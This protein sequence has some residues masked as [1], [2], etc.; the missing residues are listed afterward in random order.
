VY[1][2]NLKII[3]DLRKKL[4]VEDITYEEYSKKYSVKISKEI[5]DEFSLRN[6]QYK[7]IEERSNK[8]K[9]KKSNLAFFLALVL[10]NIFQN[11]VWLLLGMEVTWISFL[12]VGFQLMF[13]STGLISFISITLFLVLLPFLL[14]FGFIAILLDKTK[15]FHNLTESENK[16]IAEHDNSIKSALKI[17]LENA[18]KKHIEEKYSEKKSILAEIISKEKENNTLVDN[19]LIDLKK[20]QEKSYTYLISLI[21]TYSQKTI[22]PAIEENFNKFDITYDLTPGKASSSLLD[23]FQKLT[24][25]LT[26]KI[27][28]EEGLT[29]YGLVDITRSTN[30]DLGIG[31][32][33]YSIQKNGDLIL[34]ESPYII[35]YE[36]NNSSHYALFDSTKYKNSKNKKTIIKNN[37]IHDFQLFGSE[38]VESSVQ[39]IPNVA[40]AQ[41]AI[42][43]SVIGTLFNEFLFGSSYATLNGVGK[44]MS[45]I[46][47]QLEVLKVNITTIHR[48]N[49]TRR[50]QLILKDQSD[51]ELKG[52]SIYYDFNRKMGKAKNK[53]QETKI[54]SIDEPGKNKIIEEKETNTLNSLLEAQKMLKENLI[55]KEEFDALKLEILGSKK[56]KN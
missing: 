24:V 21:D 30:N 19:A 1:K 2:K 8:I 20:S 54:Q 23:S 41:P 26:D 5:S 52:I 18:Y 45:S 14:L 49:D 7:R 33:F 42:K 44:M 15:I 3:E 32:Y 56:P 36:P 29:E 39:T 6:P 11:I 38:L 31:T 43:V 48:I 50:V 37:N 34:M 47:K 4:L 25:E 35:H 55:T 16:L 10:T 22:L 27:M 53:I 28:I 46:Q 17:K 51:L 12:F 40:V 13:G 9:E